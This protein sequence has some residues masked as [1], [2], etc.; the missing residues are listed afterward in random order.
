M[1]LLV[2]A[3]DTNLVKLWRKGAQRSNKQS[4][5]R[6]PLSW[7][8]SL[9][10][11]FKLSRRITTDGQSGTKFAT[12]TNSKPLENH[13][14]LLFKPPPVCVRVTYERRDE[15]IKGASSSTTAASDASPTTVS[16]LLSMEPSGLYTFRIFLS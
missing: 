15:G 7:F 14:H 9:C 2:N 8:I 6:R 4:F 11:P 12:S 16:S 10:T 13:G 5:Q 3:F 1:C